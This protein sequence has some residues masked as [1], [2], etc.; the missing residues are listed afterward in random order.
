MEEKH[1]CLNWKEAVVVS[2]N[3]FSLGRK[4][5]LMS[6]SDQGL[7]AL[8]YR[9]SKKWYSF[10]P[11]KKCWKLHSEWH[12]HLGH[13]GLKL[14]LKSNSSFVALQHE[15]PLGHSKYFY[16]YELLWLCKCFLFSLFFFLIQP[17]CHKRL[18]EGIKRVVISARAFNSVYVR[19]TQFNSYVPCIYVIK[20]KED[21]ER[22]E[23]SL[24]PWKAIYNETI[25]NNCLF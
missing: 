8:I 20:K 13:K 3:V 25:T 5:S 1:K 18:G 12:R 19:Q 10:L 4:N 11:I 2:W 22:H 16:M 21:K 14:K 6:A 17:L 23:T 7:A 24:C 9:L 15:Q